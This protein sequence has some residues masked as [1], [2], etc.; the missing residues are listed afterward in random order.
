MNPK[1][2]FFLVDTAAYPL[3]VVLLF[4]SLKSVENAGPVLG[5]VILVL[6]G[7]VLLVS[8][9]VAHCW[10]RNALHALPPL[11]MAFL[12]A[13]VWVSWPQ[14]R[15]AFIPQSFGE[16]YYEEGVARRT[17]RRLGGMEHGRIRYYAPDGRLVRIET[18]KH[19]EENGLFRGYHDNGQL[20]ERGVRRA[21]E[22][23]GGTSKYGRCGKWRFYREDGTL[24]DVRIYEKG[25]V[26]TSGRY[27]YYKIYQDDGRVRVY[28][29]ADHAPFTGHMEKA[30][31]VDDEA[32]PL[33]Y[34]AQLVD[35]YF[36][37]PWSGYYFQS[38]SSPAGEGFSLA[39]E[40]FSVRGRS[41][42]GWRCYYS[43]GQLWCEA[44]YRDGKLEGE[45][46]EYY[47][48]TL[49]KKPHPQVKYRCNY[50]GG[51]RHGTARWWRSDGTPQTETQ[52]RNGRRD[53]VSREYDEQGRL[54]WLIP[55]RDGQREGTG[56]EY[57]VDGSRT[58]TVY[59][60]DKEVSEMRY[61][62]EGRL[63]SENP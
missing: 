56:I 5:R 41:E 2:L 38:G 9:L 58:E 57:G 40:G 24:D 7:A 17:G 48:D 37:G 61:D 3:A 23:P 10:L 18:W 14:W 49:K 62:A 53:G 21:V 33:F 47:D 25:R 51:K 26:R 32:F 42:D 15:N 34:T 27:E 39:G 19:G 28:R 16:P 63:K 13:Y 22:T 29:F 59:R 8:L 11:L 35:G 36:D 4:V 43:D 20:A 44:T 6:W 50:I 45:Y 30:G 12:I 52:Y 31:L 54:R 60:D 55:Y 46:V 1:L